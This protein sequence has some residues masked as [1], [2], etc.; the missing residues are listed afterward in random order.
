MILSFHPLY[1]ADK[2]IIC[3]G[4]PPGTDDTRAVLDAEAIVLPQGCRRDLYDLAHKNCRLV[5]PNYN[6]RFAY[7][8]K[9]GQIALFKRFGAPHPK[10]MVF[11]D[12]GVF[13][14][15]IKRIQEDLPFGFPCVFKFDWGGG[16]DTVYPV[17]TEKRLWK[18]LDL[19]AT[20]ERSGHRGF[21]LQEMIATGSRSLRVVVIGKQY[22][23]YWRVQPNKS[24]FWTGLAH[25]ARIDAAVDPDLQAHATDAV[26]EFCRCTGINLAG[27]DILFTEKPETPQ[28]YFLEINFF[29]GRQGLGGSDAYYKILIEEIDRWLRDN[30]LTPVKDRSA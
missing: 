11:E 27:F 1:V 4:R 17:A 5:F 22:Q 18:M 3:A 10:S 19:A 8:G 25:G 30:N 6:V 24:G 14:R 16:D 20:F 2:N 9:L 12:S 21:L 7:Q 23:S 29:F 13:Q 26:K 28:M 15:R